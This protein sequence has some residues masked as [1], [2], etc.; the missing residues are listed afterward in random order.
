MHLQDIFDHK[1]SR[2]SN[3][4]Q[5]TL[6]HNYLGVHGQL[7]YSCILFARRSFNASSYYT[8]GQQL[9]ADFGSKK[10]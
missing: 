2:M 5:K 6:R 10:F 4:P 7:D 8:S 9:M 1:Q 3:Q